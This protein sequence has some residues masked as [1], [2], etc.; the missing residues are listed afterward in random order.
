MSTRWSSVRIGRRLL[1]RHVGRRAE[2]DARGGELL[3][4][5]GLAHRLGHAEVG[6]QGVPAGE[7]HVVR[8]DVAVHHA[9]RVR[10]G[11]RVGHLEQDPDRVVR[12][13]SSPWRASRARSD[14]PS[15]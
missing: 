4:P 11:Q 7:H 8:L 3:P 6:H 12:S 13:G 2:R 15:T 10:V 9:R 14:S 5:G 1:R